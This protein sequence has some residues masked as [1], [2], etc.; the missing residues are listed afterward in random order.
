MRIAV[1]TSSWDDLTAEEALAVRR[2]TSVLGLGAEVDVLVA[3]GV[4]TREMRDEGLLRVVRFPAARPDPQLRRKVLR[5]LALDGDDPWDGVCA[6]H[7]QSARS[8]LLGAPRVLQEALLRSEGGDCPALYAHL[9]DV[10]YDLVVFAGCGTTSVF[11]L[12][13]LADHSKTV[14]LALARD[15]PTLWLELAGTVIDRAETIL[16]I[17]AWES[18]LIEHR[19]GAL[20][21]ERVREV[22]FALRTNRLAERTPPAHWNERA[23]VLVHCGRQPAPDGLEDLRM[24]LREA[25]ELRGL[26]FGPGASALELDGLEILPASSRTDLWRWM[27]RSLAVVELDQGALFGRDALEAMLLGVPVLAHEETGA[28]RAHVEAGNAGLWFKTSEELGEGL[29]VCGEVPVRAILADQG[30]RYA[31]GFA[32]PASFV[33]RVQ[34][35]LGVGAGS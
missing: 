24:A 11:A 18:T 32:D 29:A 30:R 23:T 31:E 21:R 12:R 14:L 19:S 8:D 28:V 26:A 20:V 5:S 7:G 34:G 17:T 16:T 22:G 15:E 2:V 25:P 10:A 27:H 1:V 3:D 6:C 4:P 9:R 33:A 13:A 35:A